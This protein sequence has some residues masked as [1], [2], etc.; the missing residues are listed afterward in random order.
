MLVVKTSFRKSM[1]M[2]VMSCLLRGSVVLI[3]LPLNAI[4][5]EQTAR[6]E[7]LEGT[8]SVF[9][10]CE[11]IST[12]ML[13]NIHRGVYTHILLS[14]ELLVEKKF[15]SILID[16]IFCSHVKLII[17]DE[18]HLVTDWSQFFH[19]TYTQLWKLQMLL[20]QKPW[21]TCTATLNEQISVIVQQLTEFNNNVKIFHISIDQSK[22]SIIRQFIKKNHKS[23]FR[24]LYFIIDNCVERSS[25]EN[26]VSDIHYVISL[27]RIS[28]TIVFLNFKKSMTSC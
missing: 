1:I 12:A 6:I 17:I 19:V 11:M 20:D 18:M 14:S 22:L 16:S 7:D 5:A 9:V 2:Q 10:S 24:S 4:G 23:N 28:K 15:H 13:V 21:F 3:I 25:E 8:R 26:S 27:Q